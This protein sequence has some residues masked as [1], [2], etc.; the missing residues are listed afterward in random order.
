METQALENWVRL[1]K[2]KLGMCDY[3]KKEGFALGNV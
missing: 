3:I 1:V 2:N